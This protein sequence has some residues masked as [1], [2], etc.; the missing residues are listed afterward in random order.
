MTADP[1]VWQSKNNDARDADQ[2]SLINML[3]ELEAD[4]SQLATILSR[5]CR[6]IYEAQSFATNSGYADVYKN[7]LKT[8]MVSLKR[9]L[10]GR[11]GDRERQFFSHTLEYLMAEVG[12]EAEVEDWIITPYKVEFGHR[13]GMG[14]LYVYRTCSFMWHILTFAK[15]ER[16]TKAFGITYRSQSKF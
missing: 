2:L 9:R 12:F 15:A 13:I 16:Y 4:H 8:M 10:I 6:S 1:G 3:D 5:S 7:D 11:L 14:G